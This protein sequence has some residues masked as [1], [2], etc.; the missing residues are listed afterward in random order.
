[1]PPTPASAH[2]ESS[3]RDNTN[4]SAGHH[5]KVRKGTRSCWECKRRKLKC[6]FSTPADSV[7][8]AC[9]RRGTSC[10]S[11]RY[12]EE[13]AIAASSSSSPSLERDRIVRVEALV[14]RLARKI[15][16]NDGLIG[17]NMAAND[18]MMRATSCDSSSRV[19]PNINATGLN[20][21]LESA[22]HTSSASLPM[23]PSPAIGSGPIFNKKTLYDDISATLHAALP[24]HE[25][26]HII[27]EAGIDVSLH[28]VITVPYAIL[29]A[30]EPGVFKGSLANI[31][32]PTTHPVLLAKYILVLATCL[33]YFHPEI[34]K[35]EI[36]R[37]SEQPRQLICRLT[38]IVSALVT[39]N[40]ELLDSIESLEC[41]MLESMIQANSGHL[42]RAWLICRRAMLVAQ[43]MGLHRRFIYQPFKVL[44][45]SQTVYPNFFWFRIVCTDRQLCLLLGLPQGSLDV[46]MASTAALEGDTVEGVF[47]RKQC[48]IAA[49]ILQLYESTESPSMNSLET[50]YEID[51]DLQTAANE[52]PNRWWLVPNLASVVH[53]SIK[54]FSETIRLFDQML[55]FN[56]LN[57]LHLPYMLRSRAQANGNSET[58]AK[59][60]KSK[61]ASTNASRELLT[62]FIMFRSF[63]RVAYALRS[64][65]FFALVAS[66]TLLIAH[67]EGHRQQRQYQQ[68]SGDYNLLAHQRNSDRAMVE[69]VL[70]TMQG[71]AKLNTDALSERAS[72]LLKMILA[73]ESEA[74]KG[75]G[76]NGFA[77]STVIPELQVGSAVTETED[78]KFLRLD[79]PYFGT[80][81]LNREGVVSMEKCVED[82]P[83]LLPQFQLPPPSSAQQPRNKPPELSSDDSLPDTSSTPQTHPLALGTA[84]LP[85][86][87]SS[88][89]IL[90]TSPTLA[91]VSDLQQYT[92]QLP[93]TIDDAVQHQ[94]Q[95][96][97]LT[98][99]VEDWPFQGVD[100]AFFD[101]L[102]NRHEE[103]SVNIDGPDFT[104]EWESPL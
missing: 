24:P 40:D 23:I 54:T 33:Q 70:E 89:P 104:A 91:A 46:S 79:I 72:D 19:D 92:L 80:V 82:I 96:P 44:D 75:N 90:P 71:V 43:M 32:S 4:I 42:R 76:G 49:R 10:I 103:R 6:S 20:V 51:A 2:L 35:E 64:I 88:A 38:D 18:G 60:N 83:S 99:A 12:P 17:N 56:L 87:S 52:M 94:Y 63:N 36:Q 45:V 28:K 98:A 39:R 7:C 97:G 41:I 37:L 59:Y 34:H 85:C 5:R 50:L 47:E 22:E 73:F 1:M 65:D 86:P 25:D 84:T 77:S 101:S 27:I 102:I 93:T 8:Q 58:A 15:G 66:M 26:I 68:N 14:E 9:R 74:A 21:S 53:D 48:V 29:E 55:Y 31:P 67:L 16:I 57:L 69:Q 81:R 3:S 13:I 11:Q 30:Q 100:M 62:R 78:G 61:L 95:Y